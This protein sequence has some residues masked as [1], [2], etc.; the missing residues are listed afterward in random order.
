M[1][2]TMVDKF[3]DLAASDWRDDLCV[4]Y[5]YEYQVPEVSASKIEGLKKFYGITSVL[6]FNRHKK[7]QR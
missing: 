1:S 7:S 5:A 4:L 2:Q 3:Y 6:T